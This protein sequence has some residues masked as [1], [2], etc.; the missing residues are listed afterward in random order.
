[1]KKINE[2]IFIATCQN[3]LT[4]AEAARKLVVL[5]FVTK[6]LSVKEQSR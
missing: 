4:M 2:Q 3:S 5:P 6:I 1:M